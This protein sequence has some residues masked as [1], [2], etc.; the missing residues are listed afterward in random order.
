MLLQGIFALIVLVSPMYVTEDVNLWNLPYAIY[1]LCLFI[2]SSGAFI[3]LVN[4]ETP[5]DSLMILGLLLAMMLILGIP[6]IFSC[7]RELHLIF[8]T[9]GCLGIIISFLVSIIRIKLQKKYHNA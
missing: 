1:C 6:G 5:Q 4:K 9:I 7:Y 2:I 3:T 8:L